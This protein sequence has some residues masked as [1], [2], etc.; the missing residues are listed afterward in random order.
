M[1][2]IPTGDGTTPFFSVQQ[3]LDGTVYTLEF[4]WN[5]R[6]KVPP[7]SIYSPVPAPGA[8]F[9]GIYDEEGITP[10]LTGIRLVADWKLG[11]ASADSRMPPGALIATDTSGAGVDPGF[12]DLG[13]R[14]ELRYFTKDD[15]TTITA[16]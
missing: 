13:S 4:R 5:E 8:W 12:A 1:I 11:K 14:V 6:C 9:M 7:S 16:P 2:S 3:V 10:I 15:V